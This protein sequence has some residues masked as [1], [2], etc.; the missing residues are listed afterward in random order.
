[1]MSPGLTSSFADGSPL[2]VT[3]RYRVRKSLETTPAATT[4]L[5]TT[6][7]VCVLLESV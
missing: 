4:V 1:M 7:T 2:Q 5:E 3:D 6:K